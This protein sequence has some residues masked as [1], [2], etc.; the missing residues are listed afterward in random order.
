[1]RR[2]VEGGLMTPKK[3]EKYGVVVEKQEEMVVRT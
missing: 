1:L 2:A 3:W